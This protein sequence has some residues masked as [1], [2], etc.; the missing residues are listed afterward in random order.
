MT[1]ISIDLPDRIAREAERAGLLSS[2][3]IAQ[4]IQER[5]RA[6]S[7]DELFEAMERMA[8]A[9]GHTPMSPEEVAAEIAAV[10]AKRP[11]SASN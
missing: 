10:R 5:L 7:V 2:D 4:L 8:E 11:H 3:A 9:G 1:S 6:Q